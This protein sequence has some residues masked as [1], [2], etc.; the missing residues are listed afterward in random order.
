MATPREGIPRAG[1]E[2]E[3]LLAFMEW[4]RRAIVSKFQGVD[5]QAARRRTLPSPT[6]MMGLL[7]HLTYVEVFWFQHSFAGLGANPLPD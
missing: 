2:F 5:E 6:S 7:Q 1:S 3:V 4:L